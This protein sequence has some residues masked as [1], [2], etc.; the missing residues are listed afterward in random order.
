M[1]EIQVILFALNLWATCDL[2]KRFYELEIEFRYGTYEG[3]A[4]PDDPR[5]KPDKRWWDVCKFGG[6]TLDEESYDV[7]E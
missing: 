3:D 7:V 4:F 5:G 6:L 2:S 1:I